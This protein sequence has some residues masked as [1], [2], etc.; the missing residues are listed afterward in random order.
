MDNNAIR[1]LNPDTGN[2]SRVN[3]LTRLFKSVILR[4]AVDIEPKDPLKMKKVTFNEEPIAGYS[5]NHEERS[6]AAN[7]GDLVRLR[8]IREPGVREVEVD[9]YDKK[10][11][12]RSRVYSAPSGGGYQ[13]PVD[14]GPETPKVSEAETPIHD[15]PAAERVR[16][17]TRSTRVTR[18]STRNRELD[19]QPSTSSPAAAAFSCRG[20]DRS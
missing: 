15:V 5:A 8:L 1:S 14:L 20:R 13:E 9:E 4:N 18:R 17:T 2:I 16:E 12:L 6:S 7:P 19:I 3:P 10:Y 11:Q